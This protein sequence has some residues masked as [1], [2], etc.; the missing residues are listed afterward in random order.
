MWSHLGVYDSVH[1]DLKEQN[2]KLVGMKHAAFRYVQDMDSTT[3][4]SSVRLLAVAVS[5]WA[6]SVRKNDFVRRVHFPQNK[7]F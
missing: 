6:M 4:V 2:P 5:V 1:A 7:H 3:C